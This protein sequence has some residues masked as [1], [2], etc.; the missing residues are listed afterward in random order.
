MN[1]KKL[2]LKLLLTVKKNY[3]IVLDLHNAN[4]RLEGRVIRV[5]RVTKVTR[6]TK[7]AEHSASSFKLLGTHL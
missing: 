2:S 7:G 5:Y 6:V 3:D 1:E 4:L